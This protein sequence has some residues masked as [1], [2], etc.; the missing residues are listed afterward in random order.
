VLKNQLFTKKFPFLFC[1]FKIISYLCTIKQIKGD[2]DMVEA[3]LRVE[4]LEN[5]IGSK[6]PFYGSTMV[7]N[8]VENILIHEYDKRPNNTIAPC[9]V[10]A[11]IAIDSVITLCEGEA[12]LKT[13]KVLDIKVDRHYFDHEGSDGYLA[14]FSIEEKTYELWVHFE[15]KH[16]TNITLSEWLQSGDFEDGGN[17]DNIYSAKAFTTIE[18]LES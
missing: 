7:K 6:N 10:Y 2:K 15:G 16:I 1:Q 11:T 5:R 18:I 8:V 17:A 12:P 4:M 14:F 9:G 3:K 13:K